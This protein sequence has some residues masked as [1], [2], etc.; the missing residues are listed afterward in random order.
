V[1]TNCVAQANDQ[2]QADDRTPAAD[3][4]D[5]FLAL[6][7]TFNRTK[8]RFMA[9]AADD[10]EWSAQILL[11][12]LATEGPMRGSDLAETL[13]FDP[14]TVSRQVAALVKE[15]LVERRSDPE[16]GRASI[17]VLT[18]RADAVLAVHET[19]RSK[20]FTEMLTGWNDDDLRRF[21][22]LLRQFTDDFEKSAD[23]LIAEQSAPRRRSTEGKR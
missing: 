12:Q 3:V 4:A 10:V 16:D 11:R 20:H 15:G 8:S 9:A 5:S 19:R 7:R 1:P 14:S 6:M 13:Q 22:A 17:L 2:P 18:P 21:A 23:C